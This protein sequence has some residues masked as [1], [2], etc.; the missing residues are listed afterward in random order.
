MKYFN[1]DV[2]ISQEM[3]LLMTDSLTTQMWLLDDR[4][5]ELRLG[6]CAYT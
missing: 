3:Y 1:N 5:K 2:Y 4:P 6:V